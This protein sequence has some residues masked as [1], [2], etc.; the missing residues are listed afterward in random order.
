M[1][2]LVLAR[3]PGELAEAEVAVGDEGAHAAGLGER[4]RVTVVGLSSLGIEPLRMGRKITEQVPRIGRES[5]QRARGIKRPLGQMA[6][7]ITTAEHDTGATQTMP[8]PAEVAG[9][10]GRLALRFA[11]G[12]LPRWARLTPISQRS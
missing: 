10:P 8:T 1:S 12:N 6:R 4:E 2:R 9:S 11:S 5:E 3:P 7:P